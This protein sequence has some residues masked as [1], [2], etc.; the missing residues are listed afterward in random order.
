MNKT[1]DSGQDARK[2]HQQ[3]AARRLN[4]KIL[5]RSFGGLDAIRFL[6]GETSLQSTYKVNYKNKPV[7]TGKT[8]VND[9]QVLIGGRQE[10][11]DLIATCQEQTGLSYHDALIYLLGLVKFKDFTPEVLDAIGELMDME[12]GGTL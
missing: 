10:A 2:Q 12:E 3:A 8:D 11:F 4:A 6:Y 5:N 9:W 1:N 7:I